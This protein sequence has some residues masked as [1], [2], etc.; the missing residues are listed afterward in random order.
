M[1]NFTSARGDGS[2]SYQD[3]SEVVNGHFFGQS[4]ISSMAA[5]LTAATTIIPEDVVAER[6]ELA[7]ELGA[8][9]T[10]NPMEVV[11]A[12]ALRE[13]TAQ[14]GVD[15]VVETTGKPE[16][17]MAA[18]SAMAPRGRVAALAVAPP[19]S[20]ASLEMSFLSSMN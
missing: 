17:F 5:R 2:V 13:H 9:A 12:S 18:L 11:L 14:R 15:C 16:V 10:I 19:G 8:T 7:R 6:L 1:R 20:V 4:S 3:G